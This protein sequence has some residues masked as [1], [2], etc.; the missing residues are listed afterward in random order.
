MKV[1]KKVLVA[2]MAA[3]SL[4]LVT[5]CSSTDSTE[6]ESASETASESAA[7][8]T[9]TGAAV[10][11]AMATSAADFG[12]MDGLVAACEAEGKLN[13]IALP[14]DW[15]NYGEIIQGFTD[16]YGIEVESQQ[17]D[18]NS[19]DEINAA[20]QNAGTDRAPDV[21]DLGQAVALNNTAM[22]APY[23]VER[24][25][26]IPAAFKDANGLWVND[27][28]GFMAVGY[29]ANKVPEITSLNDLLG[30]DFKG[31][32][33]LNG[34]PT[35]ASAGWNGVMMASIANGGSANDI[36]PGVEYFKAMNEAGNFLPVDPTPATIESGQTPVV[37]DWDYLQAG[38]VAGL[39]EKG[40]DWKIFVP[41]GAVVGGYYY[42]AV[43]ADAPN[44]ACARLWQEYLYSPDGQNEWLR[45]GAR[46]VLADVYAAEG[47]LD[48]EAFAKLPPVSGDPIVPDDQQVLVGNEYLIA[49]WSAAVGG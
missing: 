30:P 46:P 36:A 28:G 1:Q 19:Q 39:A 35:Q 13:T 25:A 7:E 21:F 9:D 27:Y 32:V 8:S 45:G 4:M 43:N 10:D 23:M 33:A 5:A 31:A 34:D 3:A 42:Q 20:T 6:A 37:F 40:I 16:K 48:A 14:P 44:P 11:A 26:D 47:T 17:P 24:F 2:G 22:Y 12:G 38:Q 29:D 15:A 49:N 41:E 18:A